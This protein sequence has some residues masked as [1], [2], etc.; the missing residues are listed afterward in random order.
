V[1]E[2]TKHKRQARAAATAALALALLAAGCGGGSG[3]GSVAGGASDLPGPVPE[4]VTFEK[5]GEAGVKAHDFTAE[6]MDGTSVQASDLWKDRP[7]V[8]V[9]TASW[10]ET[11][12]KVHR[13]AAAVAARHEG[14]ALLGIVPEDDAEPALGYAEDLDLGAPLAAADDKTWLDFA[15]REPPVVVLVAPGGTILRGWPG[16]VDQAVLEDALDDLTER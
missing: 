1:P 5:P 3:D 15:A 4:G 2:R 6:L 16:G 10:C 8:L 11:C 14:V 7:V 12:A 9:F 13:D